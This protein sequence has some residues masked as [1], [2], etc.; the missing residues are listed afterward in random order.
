MD[1]KK[2]LF[3]LFLFQ[4]I[5]ICK[6]VNGDLNIR[7]DKINK[8]NKELSSENDEFVEQIINYYAPRS[9]SVI[10]AWK[11][12]NYSLEKL[13]N[14]NKGTKLTYGLLSTPM[15]AQNDTFFISLKVPK[16]FVLNYYF[17]I[18][19]NK[20]GH[21]QDYWDLQSSGKTKVI[22][23]PIIKNAIYI[24]PGKKEERGFIYNG[25]KVFLLL[26]V[27]LIF[28]S[29]IRK[30]YL[31]EIKRPTHVEKVIFLGISLAFFQALARSVIIGIEPKSI[32]YHPANIAKILK[33]ST[34]DFIYIA[35]IIVLFVIAFLWVKNLKIKKIIYGIFLTLTLLSVLYAYLNIDIVKFLG[36]PLTFQWLYYSDFLGSIEAKTALFENLNGWIALNITAFCFSMLLLA[37]I[38]QF[39]YRLM[40]P[41]K[42]AKYIA[43]SFLGL[44]VI[45]LF[46]RIYKTNETWTKGESENPV[47]TTISSLLNP[48]SNST[49]FTAIIS[50]DMKP[51]NPAECVKS[52]IS[53]DSITNHHIKNVL[54]IILESAG[55]IYFDGYGG[56]F[57]LSP[58]LNKYAQKS[59]MY[60]QMYAS[61]PATNRTLV[62]ILGSMYPYLSYKSITQEYPDFNHPTISSVLKKLGYRTSFFSSANLDFQNSKKFLSHRNFDTVEDYSMIKCDETY[63]LDNENYKEGNGI[64]DICLANRLALWLDKDTTKSFFSM[65]WT[66]QGHYPYFFTG[67]EEDFGVSDYNFNRYLNCLKHDDELIGELLEILEEKGLSSSTLVVITGDHGEAFGQ[68]NQYGHGTGIYEENL[69]VPLYFINPELFHGE[70]K[71]DIAGMKDLATT[72]LS[73]LGIEIPEK[74]QG[75]NLLRTKTNEIFY[76]APW[77]DYLFG[78]RKN[79][80]KYI[81]NESRNT[82]EVYDLKEDPHEKINLYQPEMREEV[83]A[84]RNRIA[85]WV[86]F[87]E[88]FVNQIINQEN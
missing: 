77:S 18:V 84:I 83:K 69:K 70:R 5:S 56:N 73:V 76:F 34:D 7:T 30:K 14:W 4:F 67:K 53:D 48:N 9:G 60:D 57:H 36:K 49:F 15:T 28:L 25:W 64:D 29:W 44:V 22:E 61:A 87:Q 54:F 74:W 43:N 6:N 41:Y 24:T 35:V 82:I 63:Q 80:R 78:Y 51:F 8:D 66:V 75:R 17:W 20:Q 19:K 40:T 58:N 38:L 62:S 88:K 2:L 72:T 37:G 10:L 39:V 45:I 13:M 12:E 50:P 16:G 33:G 86:Q 65:I 3:F 85:A 31:P 79:K 11:V 68:H 52:E 23:K 42:S 46:I 26:S 59:I 55:A 32:F 47:F 27:S 71:N 1:K 21:Y 81:F